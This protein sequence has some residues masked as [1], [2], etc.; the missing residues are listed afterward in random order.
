MKQKILD[1]KARIKSL[2]EDLNKLEVSIE[3]LEKNSRFESGDIIKVEDE[4][5]IFKFVIIQS[6]FSEF[7]L[8]RFN[9]DGILDYNRWREAIKYNQHVIKSKIIEYLGYNKDY[10][11][12]KIGNLSDY[13]F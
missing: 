6:A 9:S 13:Q 5:D 11:I 1:L 4:E 7:I 3:D 10:K 12:E 8:L 2:E